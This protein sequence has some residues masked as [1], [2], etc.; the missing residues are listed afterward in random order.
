MATHMTTKELIRELRKQDFEV[1][2]T[3]QGHYRVKPPDPDASIVHM[4]DSR[5]PRAWKNSVSQLRKSGFVPPWEEKEDEEEE[6]DSVKSDYLER[7]L[8][9]Y[10]EVTKNVAHQL[11][12]TRESNKKWLVTI[13]K[14]D[15]IVDGEHGKG[16][17]SLDACEQIMGGLREKIRERIRE[18][19]E[20]EKKLVS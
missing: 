20:L 18:L 8:S 3:S 7:L 17:T 10:N 4:S 9:T 11:V 12:F 6:T 1:D 16:A 14:E 2:Q 13:P 19:Q 5:D 15:V